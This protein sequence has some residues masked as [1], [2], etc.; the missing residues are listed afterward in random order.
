MC[1]CVPGVV[2]WCD[3]PEACA[4][5]K[6]TC[7]PDGAWGACIETDDRPGDCAVEIFGWLDPTY[8]TDCC[9]STGECCQNYPSDDS[10]GCPP[11]MCR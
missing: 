4:W 8:D 2:R 3:T 7:T 1:E 11:P 10:V 5:G 6:Q 9:I